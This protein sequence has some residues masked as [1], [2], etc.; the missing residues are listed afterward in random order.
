M[1]AYHMLCLTALFAAVTITAGTD[2]GGVVPE[3]TGMAVWGEPMRSTQEVK[4]IHR[5][6]PKSW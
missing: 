1:N 2:V 5:R 3:T 6:N 4:K